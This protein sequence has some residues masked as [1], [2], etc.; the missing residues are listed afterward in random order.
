MNKLFFLL[1]LLF[2]IACRNTPTEAIL[3][4]LPASAGQYILSHSHQNISVQED[5]Y[6]QFTG[7]VIDNGLIGNQADSDVFSIKPAVKGKAY[8]KDAATLVFEPE[9]ILDYDASYVATINLSSIY[10]GDVEESLSTVKLS[11]KTQPLSI[12]VDFRDVNYAS[13]SETVDLKASVRTNNW[14]SNEDIERLITV[15]QSGNEDISLAWNHNSNY[16][17]TIVVQN[18]KRLNQDSKVSLAWNTKAVGGKSTGKEDINILPAGE[19]KFID[20]E[21]SEDKDNTLVLYFSEKVQSSQDLVGLIDIKDYN[22]DLD[23]EVAGST[24]YVYLKERIG[25]TFTLMINENIRRSDGGTLPKGYTKDLSF[26]P[27]L[28]KLELLGKGVIVP[29]TEDATFPFVATNLKSATI[30]IFEIYRDNVL[31]HLQNG[32]LESSYNLNAVG[33]IVHQEKIYFNNGNDVNPQRIALNLKD[34]IE[35]NDPGAIYR[36]NISF[37][38]SDVIELG[39]QD[40]DEGFEFEL[41][42]S[43]SIFSQ[44]GSYNY[45]QRNNPCYNTYYYG[46][47]I[48]RHV[49]LSNLGVISKLDPDNNLLL[50]VTDINSINRIGGATV[51]VYDYQQQLISSG[52][53]KQDGIAIVSL[54]K[55]PAFAI[56]TNRNQFAYLNLRDNQALSNSDFD[57]SGKK[58]SSGIDAMIYGERGVWRPGDTL[59]INVMLEDKSG[60]LPADHPVTLEV[61]DS[62]NKKHYTQTTSQHLGQIYYFPV[63]TSQASPTG[64]YR[65]KFSVGNNEFYKTIKV[66]TIKPN[67]LKIDLGLP[68]NDLD[69]HSGQDIEIAS[70]WL[71]GASADGLK[72]NVNVDVNKVNT[73]FVG[74]SNYE[75]DDPSRRVDAYSQAIFD[76]RLDEN[77]K[78]IIKFPA[79]KDKLYPGKVKLSFNTKVFEKSGNYSEHNIS[80]IAHPYESYVG[81]QVPES[82]WGSKRIDLDKLDYI[83][84]VAVDT[85]G[86]PVANRQLNIGMYEADWNWWYDRGYSSKYNYNHANHSG[87]LYKDTLSTDNS[88]KVK[89][90]VRFDEY[91]RYMIRICDE[92]SGHCTGEL[93]YAGRSW[94]GKQKQGPQS[95]RM[96][97][98]KDA[99]V[100]G[101]EVK[102]NVPS[103]EGGEVF[104]TVENGEKILSTFWQ[105]TGKAS[106]EISIP[107][108]KEMTPNVYVSAHL[109]QKYNA[110]TNDLPMRMYGVLP[111]KVTD[112]AT[113]IEPRIRIADEIRPD[114]VQSIT[115]SEANN[116]AMY[117]TLAVVDEGLLNLTNFKTPDCWNY[118]NAKQALGIK[119]WDLYDY[120]LDG[121]GGKIDKY[122]SIGGDDAASQQGKDSDQNRFRPVVQHLGTFKV[123]AGRKNTHKINVKD[124]V[125]AVRVMVV[126]RNNQSYGSADKTVLV[127][128]PLMTQSTLPRVLGIGETLDLN[129]NIFAMSD[130][131]RNVDVSIDTDNLIS[132][133]LTNASLSFSKQGDQLANFPIETSQAEG[134]STIKV[135][136]SS[137]GETDDEEIN[138]AVRNP[139]PIISK[140]ESIVI[141]AGEKIT[142]ELNLFGTPGTNSASVEVTNFLPLDLS[143]RLNYLI[144]YPYGCIEQ[145]VSS[146]FPQLY[147]ADIVELSASEKNKSHKSIKRGIERLTLFQLNNGGMSYWP[148]RDYESLWGSAYA[149][150]FLTEAKQKG[151]IVSQSMIDELADYCQKTAKGYTHRQEDYYNTMEL[152]QAYILYVLARAGRADIGSMNRLRNYKNLNVSAAHLLGAAYASISKVDIA[153]KLISNKELNIKPYIETGDTYG[154][155]LRDMAIIAQALI[156]MDM[157]EEAFKVIKDI[158]K[159]ISAQRWYSTQAVA[160]SL[161]SIGQYL[162]KYPVGDLNFEYV[163]TKG[164]SSAIQSQ[165][166]MWKDTVDVSSNKSVTIHNTS[167]GNLYVNLVTNGKEAVSGTNPVQSRHID[168]DVKYTDLEGKKINPTKLKQGQDFIASVT[169]G[170]NGS[171]SVRLDELALE[172][173][174]PSGWEIN[175]ER[176]QDRVTSTGDAG[177]DYRDIR[178]DKVITF[179]DL[180]YRDS[181]TFSTKLTATY[182]GRFYFPAVYVHAMYDNDISAKTSGQWIEVTKGY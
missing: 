133:N 165:K 39:C 30:E 79:Q 11:F 124:Y 1:C 6:I 88:G 31:Q 86:Q 26:T 155:T 121:H 51:N 118:F 110:E 112:P 27:L 148:G 114:Q 160:V 167:S 90:P 134:M 67:R 5:I 44:R 62:R 56:V 99:Y 8:W 137:G 142:K 57:V 85:S 177:Y 178:D 169:I 82:R 139:N 159:D 21:I 60:T 154:S 73:Q 52:A 157:E 34:Y 77:G 181:T 58:T 117:Y 130:N 42:K 84:L 166:S 146:V 65:A 10:S 103:V 50:A 71:H 37:V 111:V 129:A 61:F 113:Q 162:V 144:H 123:D 149:L 127:K 24:V 101:D 70:Q 179:F 98:D 43:R 168:I 104:V 54:S 91:G 83:E 78:G 150:H 69:I 20:A 96:K 14:I 158:A 138:I 93:F 141:K 122:I 18:V 28:P 76:K 48:S 3:Q 15:T 22:K 53:T 172:F 32:T 108:T 106:T 176:L 128:K 136:A 74:Y 173:S 68:D 119:T 143:S 151:Y 80:T 2:F 33:A 174:I 125:G 116:S 12:D 23:F 49:L 126:A 131:I 35:A 180:G 107:V 29:T 109:V 156:D 81:V 135:V 94:G 45:Q 102:I 55:K 25:Q 40:G 75:F 140:S 64:N 38:P 163:D 161:S 164:E 7:A 132:S 87:A 46:K 147:L 115:V 97:T 120:V 105:K 170:H 17:R 16:H 182:A 152:Q 66:E 9:T 95:L 72:A 63:P 100:I 89:Y 153:K 175:N 92:V 145:T 59:H 36:V 4:T 19:F 171:R 41:D 47:G 13:G